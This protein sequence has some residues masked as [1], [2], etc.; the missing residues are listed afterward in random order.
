[1]KISKLE[2]HPLN[3]KMHNLHLNKNIRLKIDAELN[4]AIG[5]E[6]DLMM[7]EIKASSI[8]NS[9]GH[10]YIT[11]TLELALKLASIELVSNKGNLCRNTV[12]TINPLM[13][14]S[15]LINHH[16]H[17]GIFY[18]DTFKTCLISFSSII[19]FSFM[20]FKWVSIGLLQFAYDWFSALLHDSS[21][22][23]P[24]SNKTK[25]CALQEDIYIDEKQ[26]ILGNYLKFLH[27]LL[28]YFGNPIISIKGATACWY[29][30]VGSI[31]I[32]FFFSALY[33]FKVSRVRVDAF[34]YLFDHFN[35]R[36][37]LRK[38]VF[39]TLRKMIE[40]FSCYETN[41]NRKELF[42]LLPFAIKKEGWTSRFNQLLRVNNPRLVA[43][44]NLTEQLKR[45]QGSQQ[46]QQQ[47]QQKQV[48]SPNFTSRK[49]LNDTPL[50]LLTS[51]SSSDIK[52]LPVIILSCYSF[53]N[54]TE[55]QKLLTTNSETLRTR[56]SMKKIYK[57]ILHDANLV[58]LV[59]PASFST[60]YQKL[61]V[62]FNELFLKLATFTSIGI[63]VSLAFVL[64]FMELKERVSN[65]LISIDCSKWRN[66]AVPL[67]T[68][69]PELPS[70]TDQNDLKVFE[71]YNG[72]MSVFINLIYIESKYYLTERNFCLLLEIAL[73]LIPATFVLALY[74]DIY[75]HTFADKQV[76]IK[77]VQKQ[78]KYCIKLLYKRK[79]ILLLIRKQAD[80]RTNKEMR[81]NRKLYHRSL[82]NVDVDDDDKDESIKIDYYESLEL[83]DYKLIKALTVTYLNYE[84]FRRQQKSY[85]R[86]M[87][88]LVFQWSVLIGQDLI[89][90]YIVGTV[91][92]SSY[93]QFL[94]LLGTFAFMFFNLYLISGA[95]RINQIE[96]LIK[97]ILELLA[98]GANNSMQLTHIMDLWRRQLIDEKEAK[99]LFSLKIFG[100]DISFEKIL[101]L[102][103]YLVALWFVL[104]RVTR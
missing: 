102:N 28:N 25:G 95:F 59:R 36:S 103:G 66:L 64:A 14:F 39:D 35:E 20:S 40:S 81:G 9:K 10:I 41:L 24:N 55:H 26:M 47:Q 34:A 86:L 101:T 75:G 56:L 19:L 11:R 74:F 23:Y 88:F 17:S 57:S 5:Q 15:K 99:Q 80:E 27:G 98:G 65:R 85:Q 46:Q 43:E 77:Q 69:H 94:L 7:E 29:F 63:V 82:N 54:L 104:S 49:L 42:K 13:L 16:K 91:I 68:F 18:L 73:L 97:S 84:L 51:L 37:R 79:S 22:F 67:N 52:M 93:T 44:R 8:L 83:F 31:P 100:I 32:I 60:K 72:K 4:R 3:G 2:T 45:H 58:D 30:V 62:I 71:N 61:L 78:V 6:D 33:F 96:K 89:S 12:K 92:K 21:E 48:V 53:Q 50:D 38:E 87:N 1:M 90:C 76:W 70:I